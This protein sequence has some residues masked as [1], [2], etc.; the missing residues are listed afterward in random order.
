M[1]DEVDR[2]KRALGR[3]SVRLSTTALSDRRLKRVQRDSAIGLATSAVADESCSDR[4]RISTRTEL[5]FLMQLDMVVF[6]S[7][8]RTDLYSTMNFIL[9]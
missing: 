3:G 9:I 7:R 1:L 6:P 2:R 4:P 5:W 8:S